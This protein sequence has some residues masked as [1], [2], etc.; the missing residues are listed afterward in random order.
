MFVLLYGQHPT[1]PIYGSWTF[2]AGAQL[3]GVTV[4]AI[5][6]VVGNR[7]TQY[8]GPASAF[9]ALSDATANM[10]FEQ[11]ILSPYETSTLRAWFQLT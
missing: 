1:H 7:L 8:D 3:S 2:A 6:L 5:H 10:N 11:L 9:G 4:P